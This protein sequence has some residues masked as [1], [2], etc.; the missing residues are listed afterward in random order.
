MA[1]SLDTREP[2]LKKTRG[3]EK[4]KMEDES[5]V[6]KDMEPNTSA[7]NVNTKTRSGRVRI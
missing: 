1:F 3:W 2:R 7:M 4:R 6:A 5:K